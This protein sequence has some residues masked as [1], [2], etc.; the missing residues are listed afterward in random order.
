VEVIN[1]YVSIAD[2]YISLKRDDEALQMIQK[3]I[4]I[5]RALN[6]QDVKDCTIG[7][8]LQILAQI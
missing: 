8:Y 3:I 2:C 4:T 1:T 5:Y 7:H 6:G